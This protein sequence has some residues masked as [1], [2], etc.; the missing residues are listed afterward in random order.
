[1]LDA[2]QPSPAHHPGTQHR[3][4]R[5]Q[6]RSRA[7]RRVLSARRQLLSRNFSRH[8]RNALPCEDSRQADQ[9]NEKRRSE[10]GAPPLESPPTAPPPV[11]DVPTRSEERRGGK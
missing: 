4:E 2:S 8:P 5:H 3:G 11:Q 7:Q 1:M 9:E 6:H 10:R